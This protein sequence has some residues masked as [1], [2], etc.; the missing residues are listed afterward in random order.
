MLLW[1]SS[2][3]KLMLQHDGFGAMNYVLR[4]ISPDY[5]TGGTRTLYCGCVSCGEPTALRC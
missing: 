5:L 4:R 1:N 3:Q 2:N